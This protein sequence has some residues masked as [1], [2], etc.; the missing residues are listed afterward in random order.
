M[1]VGTVRGI[2]AIQDSEKVTSQ[3]PR[4]QGGFSG[5][6]HGLEIIVLV[7]RP[8]GRFARKSQL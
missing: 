7:L 3:D 1:P 2:L 5:Y 4:S 6:N 8:G